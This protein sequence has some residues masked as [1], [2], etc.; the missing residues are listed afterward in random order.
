ME[1]G[2]DAGT[3]T[4]VGFSDGSASIYLSSGGGMIGGHGQEPIRRAAQKFV[5]TAREYQ[6]QMHITTEFP[7]AEKDQT[8][9][10]LLTDDGGYTDSA[11]T[12][13]LATGNHR[14]S[15]LFIS[16][17]EIVTQYR[18]WNESAGH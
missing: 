13:E 10:Y 6:P 17:Q 15:G 14:L 5:A 1:T 18:I 12:E 16:G 9:F 8:I 3:A 7:F 4:V 11:S 2:L